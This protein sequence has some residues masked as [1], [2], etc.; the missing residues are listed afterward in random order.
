MA[1]QFEIGVPFQCGSP[2]KTEY[3]CGISFAFLVGL[4]QV[5][6][7]SLTV[8]TCKYWLFE[9]NRDIFGME[10]PKNGVIFCHIRNAA[11]RILR[12][13]LCETKKKKD[14]H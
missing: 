11:N 3:D 12:L 4:R 8:N 10:L 9:R 14:S 5:C 2:L 6:S 13:K 7:L 1:G